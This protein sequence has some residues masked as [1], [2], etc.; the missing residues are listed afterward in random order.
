MKN[1][2]REQI[3]EHVQWLIQFMN[4]EYPNGYEFVINSIGGDLK[5]NHQE[6]TFINKNLTFNVNPDVLKNLGT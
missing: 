6:M 1:Y 2:T 5:C 4:V 3:E